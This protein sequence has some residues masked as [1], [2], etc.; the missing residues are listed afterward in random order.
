MLEPIQAVRDRAVEAAKAA[1]VEAL[2]G[3]LSKAMVEVERAVL[4][5]AVERACAVYEQVMRDGR[6]VL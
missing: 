1:M 2:G 4:R 3:D 5:H 6:S